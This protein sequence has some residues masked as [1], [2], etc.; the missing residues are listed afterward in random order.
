[1]VPF[2][3]QIAEQ[4]NWTFDVEQTPIKKDAFSAKNVKAS[5]FS[6]PYFEFSAARVQKTACRFCS[7]LMI[8]LWS[9]ASVS[10]R[11]SCTA[12]RLSSTEQP[13]RSSTHR[14][15]NIPAD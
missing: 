1:M 14:R 2:E 5:Q 8:L 7:S 9:A 11:M 15:P 4:D 10:G 3:T 12:E 13:V 6:K